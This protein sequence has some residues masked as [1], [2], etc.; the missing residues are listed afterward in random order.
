MCDCVAARTYGDRLAEVLKKQTN[1]TQLYIDLCQDDDPALTAAAIETMMAWPGLGF[2]NRV[3]TTLSYP[4]ELIAIFTEME[5]FDLA[6]KLVENNASDYEMIGNLRSDKSINAI[7]LQ[8][9]ARF[10]RFAEQS[11]LPPSSHPVKCN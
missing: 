10:Q 9:D 8:C 3:E 1:S 5:E 2:Q 11:G 6:L 7:R 4:G